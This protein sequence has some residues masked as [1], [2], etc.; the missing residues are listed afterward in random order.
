[1]VEAEDTI[2]LMCNPQEIVLEAEWIEM[3]DCQ[4]LTKVHINLRQECRKWAAGFAT[5]T[6]RRYYNIHRWIRHSLEK[7]VG[8]L[9]YTCLEI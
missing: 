8:P 9:L 6:S 4:D 3:K 5:F 1:M 7:V 2:K